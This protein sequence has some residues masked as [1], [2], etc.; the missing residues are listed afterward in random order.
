M[1][2][3]GRNAAIGGGVAAAL[4]VAVPAI[5][6]AS[7]VVG[8]LASIFGGDDKE[9]QARANATAILNNG[10]A[11]ADSIRA[12]AGLQTDVNEAIA[13]LNANAIIEAT[14]FNANQ[15]L[16]SSRINAYFQWFGAEYDVAVTKYNEKISINNAE[17]AR[18]N[19]NLAEEQ[20]LYN[21]ARIQENN[22]RVLGEQKA[23][24]AKSGVVIDG[25]AYDVLYDTAIQSS[26]ESLLAITAG[27]LLSYSFLIEEINHRN[28]ALFLRSQAKAQ[29]VQGYMESAYTLYKGNAEAEAI[30]L[31]GYT[32]ANLIMTE[33]GLQSALIDFN[34]EQAATNTLREAGSGAASQ[35]A[36]GDAAGDLGDL[37]GIS[38][39][40]QGIGGLGN[41]FGSSG[42]SNVPGG[43]S[44]NFV[45]IA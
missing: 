2:D 3:E 15:V 12:S 25:S 14:N 40:L 35:R 41:L 32:Q 6:V 4:S 22:Q 19:A 39:I 34:A 24:F 13:G 5:G 43:A 33:T 8:G 17:I 21:S 31:N 27:D 30:L 37:Q 42:S 7:A 10:I 11:N 18:T 38:S 28:D 26:R 45:G 16:Q 20:A 23:G 36:Q 9:D 1:A 29:R 44:P